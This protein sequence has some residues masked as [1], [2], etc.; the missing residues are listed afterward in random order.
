MTLLL[1]CLVHR[2]SE[3]IISHPVLRP[4]CRTWLFRVGFLWFPGG[5]LSQR[6]T[7]S[8]LLK[9]AGSK[10]VNAAPTVPQVLVV[11][12]QCIV[13]TFYR[14]IT[15]PPSSGPTVC[16]TLN[17][18]HNNCS[19]VGTSWEWEC[20]EVHSGKAWSPLP[21][22]VHCLILIWLL[23]RLKGK[24]ACRLAF[25]VELLDNVSF[26]YLWSK[27]ELE[28]SMAQAP[29]LLEQERPWM[30]S[31]SFSPAFLVCFS[32]AGP[33]P[34]SREWNICYLPSR[35]ELTNFVYYMVLLPT[36]PSQSPTRI[37]LP[38]VVWTNRMRLS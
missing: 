1:C 24:S 9:P 15:R 37:F 23:D 33:C 12:I 6:W 22:H 11:Y 18:L 36:L 2:T 13:P 17:V 16:A 19:S 7:S 30:V 4:S 34:P 8:E 26:G 38:R 21:K 10:A 25:D 35:L 31:R 28:T 27:E 32:R 3:S 5:L 14:V 20:R 29:L